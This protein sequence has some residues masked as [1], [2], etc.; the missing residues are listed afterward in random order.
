MMQRYKGLLIILLYDLCV[1]NYGVVMSGTGGV[2]TDRC[3]V[4]CDQKRCVA[5]AGHVTYM[6]ELS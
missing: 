3:N 5:N 1:H 4:G 2:I 6:H